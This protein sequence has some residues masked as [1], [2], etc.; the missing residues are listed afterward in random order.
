MMVGKSNTIGFIVLLFI[1]IYGCQRDNSADYV[2]APTPYQFPERKNGYPIYEPNTDNPLTEEGIALGRYLF[3]DP[4]LSGDST[5]RCADCHKQENAFADPK[6]FSIG[7][8]GAQ[9]RRN[10][11]ALFNLM[12]HPEFFWDGRASTLREQVVVPIEDPKEMNSSMSEVLKKLNRSTFYRRLFYNAFGKHIITQDLYAKAMEQFL[13]TLISFNSE[14]DKFFRGEPTSF[15]EAAFRGLT[16]FNKE[17]QL[18]GA[19]C[20]HCHGNIHLGSF[21]MVNNGL[22]ETHNSDLGYA[23]TT[24]KDYDQGKFKVVSLRNIA[25]TAPYMH[26]GRFATLEE[27]IDFYAQGVHANSP[28]IDP[29]MDQIPKGLNL[30]TQQKSDLIE[31][32]KSFTDSEFVNN[33]NFSNPF[34]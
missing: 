33:P 3:Y 11:M 7:I 26:D 29:Q 5:Q 9:G 27:V 17:P 15:S 10:G 32:L 6:R 19:D 25:L 22:D 34:D 13:F 21:K 14:Y 20:F 4:I 8:S 2:F 31:F 16:L 1:S 23:E 24:G 18:G 28:N 30:T 12:W